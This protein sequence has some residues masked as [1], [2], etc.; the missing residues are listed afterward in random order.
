MIE[1]FRV[2]VPQDDLDGLV[3]RLART[4]WP[5]GTGWAELTGLVEHWQA[6]FDW[7]RQEARLN[8]FPQ[9]IATVNGCRVHFLHVRS[10]KPGALPLI[11][12][13]GGPGTVFG[14]LDDLRV[15]ATDFHLVVPT[16]PGFPFGGVRAGAEQTAEA[17][18]ELMA[19]LGYVRYGVHGGGFGTPVAA[20]LAELHPE[21]AFR[22]QLDG[23]EEAAKPD[24]GLGAA[25][26]AFNDSP[27]GLLEWCLRDRG[28]R[29]D[30]ALL[31]DVTTFWLAGVT[32]PPEGGTMAALR[33]PEI[34][35]YFI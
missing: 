18:A 34:R 12:G 33:V 13:R 2:D 25:A 31:T 3:E 32:P 24:D 28:G 20:M 19:R 6:H 35:D 5:A 8:S 23:L 7:R 10:Q 1:S 17:W 26:V 27:A 11:V 9:F 30:E 22:V 29:D 14:I 15:L 4:R 21:R 16:L